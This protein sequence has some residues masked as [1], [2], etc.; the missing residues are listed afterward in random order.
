M[1]DN[2]LSSSYLSVFGAEVIDLKSGLAICGG[3]G[4]DAQIQGDAITFITSKDGRF[5][6]VG[7]GLVQP[8]AENWPLMVGSSYLSKDTKLTVLGGGATCYAMGAYWTER[9]YRID[10]SSVPGFDK[11]SSSASLHCR[12]LDTPK[13]L[14]PDS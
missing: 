2:G 8:S 12:Y 5:E 9:P 14:G 1:E 10:I 6:L 7:L 4:E 3:T 11:S 13:I